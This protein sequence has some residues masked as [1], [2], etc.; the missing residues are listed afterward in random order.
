MNF[1]TTHFMPRSC[2]KILDTV[3]FGIPRSA[4]SSPTVRHQSLLMAAH[5]RSTFS[6]VLLVAGLPQHGSL[7]TDS[8]PSL[9]CLCYTF[10]CTTLIALSLKAFCIIQIVSMEECSSLMQSLMQI[11]CSARSVILNAMATQYT[12]SLNGVYCPH[13]VKPSL[14]MHAHSSPLSLAARLH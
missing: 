2:I 9:K 12:C 4:S 14:F 13:T 7:S 8:R 10:I 6:D 11:C 3:V 1:A 5:T